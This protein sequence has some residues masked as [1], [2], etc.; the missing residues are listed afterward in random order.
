MALSVFDLFKIGIGPSSSHTVGPMR[1]AR[2]FAVRLEHEGLLDTTARVCSELYG[3]LGCDRPRPRQR[4]GGAARPA[5]ARAGHGGRG[6]DRR[7]PE[8]G[9][10]REVARP[11]RPPR[12]RLRR[13]GRPAVPPPPDPALP[14]QR[15]ALHRL[16][17]GRG[18]ARQPR[19]LL[20]GR[21]FRRQRRG[22]GR[23]LAAEG[24]RPPT[25]PCCPCPSAAARTCSPS[26]PAKASRSPA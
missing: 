16:R 25:Q 24:N 26:R 9:A 19:V 4:Q 12:C 20:G 23:R 13:K 2:L 6:T 18:G 1:A 17:R 21:R 3:S 11:A 22:R 8:H 7:P 10:Q 14:R 15:H 5:R